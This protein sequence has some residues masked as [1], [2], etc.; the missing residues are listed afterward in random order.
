MVPF[1]NIFPNLHAV[2]DKGFQIKI[3]IILKLQLQETDK[4]KEISSFTLRYLS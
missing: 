3:E 4:I 2:Q 1:N